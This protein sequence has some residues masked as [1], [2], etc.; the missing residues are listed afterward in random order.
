MTRVTRDNFAP[1]RRLRKEQCS[2]NGQQM[3]AL[4]L[5]EEWKRMQYYNIPLVLSGFY[6]VTIGYS[7][8][9]VWALSLAML[10]FV[11]FNDTSVIFNLYQ[12]NR[13]KNAK[14]SFAESIWF[15]PLI[16]ICLGI[17]ITPLYLLSCFSIS[18][19]FLKR[20]IV[21]VLISYLLSVA[22]FVYHHYQYHMLEERRLKYQQRYEE[23]VAWFDL[24]K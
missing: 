3:L 6:H 5:I 11:V 21:L 8:D 20:L 2:I 7:Y 24:L 23:A 19:L 14:Y 22:L 12:I 17:V 9:I 13:G 10:C 18:I 15:Y 4:S 1:L 16:I